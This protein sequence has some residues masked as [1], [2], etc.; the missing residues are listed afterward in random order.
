MVIP[1]LIVTTQSWF[2]SL[3]PE[4]QSVLL[5]IT[6]GKKLSDFIQIKSGEREST[7]DLFGDNKHYKYRLFDVLFA[8]LKS[9]NVTTQHPFKFKVFL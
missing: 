4:G 3:C 2:S 8:L 5:L 1:F 6:T 9:I 7:T